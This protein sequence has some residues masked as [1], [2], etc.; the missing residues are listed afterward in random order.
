MEAGTSRT[1]ARSADH[2]ATVFCL[3]ILCQL[4]WLLMADSLQYAIQLSCIH[5]ISLNVWPGL[6]IWSYGRTLLVRRAKYTAAAGSTCSSGRY[7]ERGQWQ[8]ETT[9]SAVWIGRAASWMGMS[10]A[11]ICVYFC[12]VSLRASS[13]HEAHFHLFCF[14]TVLNLGME[15]RWHNYQIRSSK[16]CRRLLV[17]ICTH[18]CGCRR[19][20]ASWC[21]SEYCLTWMN[22]LQCQLPLSSDI[23]LTD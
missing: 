8:N 18:S 19:T 20:A 9:D 22:V 2:S 21:A 3:A 15:E 10:V 17:M 6:D 7:G 14:T 11:V 16:R 5:C 23:Y 1:R 12:T 4:L 13:S